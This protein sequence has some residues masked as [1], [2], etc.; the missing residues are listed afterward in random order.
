MLAAYDFIARHA[1]DGDIVL[2]EGYQRG[3]EIDQSA[4]SLLYGV[5]ANIKVFG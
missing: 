3:V 1:Q 4:I 2:K 5:R